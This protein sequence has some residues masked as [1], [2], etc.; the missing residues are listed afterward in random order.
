MQQE[1][2][3]IV[4]CTAT[5][6][7]APARLKYNEIDSNMKDKKKD[8]K[9]EKILKQLAWKWVKRV[10]DVKN[11]S[12]RHTVVR[13]KEAER[14]RESQRETSNKDP[15]SEPSVGIQCFSKTLNDRG[16]N[17]H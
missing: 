5:M 16:N 15:G 6:A 17:K 4:H 10:W 11:K 9:E 12:I 1:K 3:N 7:Y 13:Y 8:Q 14:K 2:E